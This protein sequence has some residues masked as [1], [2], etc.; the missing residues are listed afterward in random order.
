MLDAIGFFQLNGLFV[1]FMSGN[2]THL[3]MTLA[4][5]DWSSAGVIL[6]LVASFVLGAM[7][8]ALL[9]DAV[10]PGRRM[11]TIL[12]GE[13]L[14]VLLAL[15]LVAGGRAGFG[16]GLVSFAMGWQNLVHRAVAGADIGRSFITGA[17]FGLGHSIARALRGTGPIAAALAFGAAWFAF[18]AGA[19]GGGLLVLHLGLTLSLIVAALV[20][21][22]MVFWA[23][24]ARI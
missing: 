5:G 8:G 12:G 10:S 23:V 15:A 14:L 21:G 19:T 2:S 18:I 4:E 20:L 9:F 7:S 11:R 6:G 1:S 22:G 3:G 16:L 13:F 24:V 17:L